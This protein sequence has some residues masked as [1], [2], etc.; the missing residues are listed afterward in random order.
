MSVFGPVNWTLLNALNNSPRNSSDIG[1]R[2]VN[3]REISV[4]LLKVPGAQGANACFAPWL[5]LHGGLFFRPSIG[6]RAASGS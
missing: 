5:V 4:S 3:R 6:L 1:S 2:S